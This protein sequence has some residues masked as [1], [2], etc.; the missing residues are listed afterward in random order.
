MDARTLAVIFVSALAV[1]ACGKS[2]QEQPAPAPPVA[3]APVA[4][5]VSAEAGPSFVNKV[6]R[7]AES[8]QVAPGE[9][10]TFLSDGTLVMSSP[11]AKSAFGS[12]RYEDGRLTI[13]EEG[14]DYPTDILALSE[15]A[16][17]IRMHSPGEPVEMLLEPAEQPAMASIAEA[18]EAAVATQEAVEPVAVP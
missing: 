17:R 5:P 14:R 9:T 12:W 16:F 18:R 13:T 2:E 6:W 4:A 10:R 7:V 11:N 15:S 8:K 3:P 1:T